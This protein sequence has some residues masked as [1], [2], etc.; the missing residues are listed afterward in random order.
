MWGSLR[1]ISIMTYK[2]RS[3]HVKPSLTHGSKTSLVMYSLGMRGSWYEK[4]LFS[5]SIQRRW[6]DEGVVFNEL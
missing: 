2:A 5:P 6:S 1:L 4:T 3:P